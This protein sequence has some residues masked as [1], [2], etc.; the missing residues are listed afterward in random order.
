MSNFAQ[1]EASP[2][3]EEHIDEVSLDV[4]HIELSFLA[5]HS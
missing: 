3:D 4:K 5:F 2:V 1:A